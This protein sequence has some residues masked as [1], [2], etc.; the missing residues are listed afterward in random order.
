MDK[1]ARTNILFYV[2]LIDIIITSGSFILSYIICKAYILPQIAFNNI[3]VQLPIIVAITTIV[4]LVYGRYKGVLKFGEL[5]DIYNIFNAICL[6]NIL[7][8]VLV[9]MNA[10]LINQE[11]LI[12]PLSIIIVHSVLSFLGLLLSRKAY[13]S[14]HDFYLRKNHIN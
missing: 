6:A 1:T 7:T 4:L 11:E 10:K 5:E 12:V 8:I 2:I 9:V 3:L 13:K 14:F